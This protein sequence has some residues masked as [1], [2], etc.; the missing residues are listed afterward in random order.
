[1]RLKAAISAKS[2]Y[3]EERS[4]GRRSLRKKTSGISVERRKGKVR[5]CNARFVWEKEGRTCVASVAEIHG[6]R[7]LLEQ[8]QKTKLG[9]KRHERGKVI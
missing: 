2:T 3:R 4:S 9:R 6:E 8:Q 7:R 5:P 1:V